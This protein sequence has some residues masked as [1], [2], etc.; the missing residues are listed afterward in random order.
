MT[1]SLRYAGAV[2]LMVLVA[3]PLTPQQ[4]GEQSARPVIR[5]T[6]DLVQVDAVVTDS[7]GHRVTDL[8]PEDFQILEDG[9]P[10]KITHFSYVPGTSIAGG[11]APVNR[12][13][14]KHPG[15]APDAIP[16][17]ARE[18][19]P[20]E[21]RRTI[22]LMADDLALSA[23]D[24]PNVRKAMK[25]FVDGQMQAGDLVSIMTTSGG[26]GAM[27]QLTND[28]RQ[29][30]ALIDRIHY[31]P[32]RVGLTWYEPTNI[33]DKAR[34]VQTAS[35][36]RLNTVR[37]PGNLAGTFGAVA[38]A[39]QGL[40]EMPGRKAIALFS[41]GSARSVGGIVELA[42]RASVVLYTF[43][44]RGLASFFLTAV[45]VCSS[46]A[47]RGGP[48]KIGGAEGQRQSSYLVSQESLEQM[49]RGTGGIFFHDDNGLDKGLANALDD[50]SGYYLIAYQPQRGD[51][52]TVRG[53]SK[54]HKTE[55]KVLRHGLQVRSRNGFFGT[56]DS[57]PVTEPAARRKL[58]GPGSE[59][60][61]LRKALFSPFQA[62]GFPVQLSAF[63]SASTGKDSKTGRRPALLRAMLAIDARGLKFNDTA[64]GKQLDLV[65]VAVAYGANNEVVTSSDKT[66][67]AAM[68]PDEMNQIIASGLV[69]NL[70]IEIPKPGPYQLRV[71]AWDA[72]S[73]R[74]GS[75]STFVEI[76]DFNRA[77]LALSSVQLYDS[78]SQ[79][80][81]ELT[82]AG[83][84]GAGSPVTRVFAP[85][86][87]LKYDC[88]VYGAASDGQ[89]G[90]PKL[91]VAVTLFRGPERIYSGQPMA[92][93]IAGADST[94][95]VHAAG[96]I[97]LPATL[98]PGNYALELS[99]SDRLEKKQSQG[100]AQW[101]DFTLVNSK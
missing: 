96:E 37:A 49:A 28:N 11:P 46:C 78:D 82:R 12:A 85:G 41:D 13:P 5:V 75:A 69:Y 32:G 92:L 40:H 29:L 51:F 10:Q 77:G 44:A 56:P 68:M 70:E 31:V 76:P 22:V 63:Y 2:G 8:K 88:I 17:P 18:L 48:R 53:H 74:A 95:A 25:G 14:Q 47:G 24:I 89:T 83:V 26:T 34:Q 91:D 3:A 55:V 6:V 86:A 90:K 1:R 65:I 61:G 60:E 94:A 15:K 99:V 57:P 43:D 54:F 16:P 66:F 98:P 71:A 33:G 50:M 84:I 39:I 45:D 72:N 81:E 23:D 80:N 67:S 4:T 20:E 100:A 101:V 7:Q 64:D 36:A 59:R 30:L 62:N 21:V 58:A 42:N 93:A 52:D 79:R 73:E 87:V 38:Y 27:Q 97:K 19:R 35:N 9:K